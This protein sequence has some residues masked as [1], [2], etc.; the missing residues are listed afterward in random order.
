MGDLFSFGG[1][2]P[3]SLPLGAIVRC[4]CCGGSGILRVLRPFWFAR[5]E[6]CPM[7]AGHGQLRLPSPSDHTVEEEG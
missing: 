5:K 1:L 7:C 4:G 6:K 3:L 2:Y